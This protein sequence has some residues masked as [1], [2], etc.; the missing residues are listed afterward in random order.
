MLPEHSRSHATNNNTL[1]SAAFPGKEGQHIP[2]SD[3]EPH[4]LLDA[5]EGGQW[6]RGCKLQAVDRTPQVS[7]ERQL[8]SRP[9]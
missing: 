1:G 5:P 8:C 4:S 9:L 6:G 3:L 7:T 2:E